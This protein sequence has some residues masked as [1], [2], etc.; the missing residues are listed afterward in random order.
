MGKRYVKILADSFHV[1]ANENWTCEKYL[2]VDFANAQG[3]VM[4]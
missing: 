3:V 1:I 4:F 2:V